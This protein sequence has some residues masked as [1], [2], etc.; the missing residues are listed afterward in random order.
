LPEPVETGAEPA[1]G[2]PSVARGSAPLFWAQIAGNAGLFAALVPI[3]R[4]LGPAGRGTLAFVT[5]TAIVAATVSRLGVTEATTV[6][7]AQRPRLRSVLLANVMLAVTVAAVAAAGVVCGAL[8]LAPGLRPPGVG[9]PELT[10]LA[11]GMVASA[12]AD[13]GYMFTLGCSRFRFHAAV[14]IAVAWLYAGTIAVVAL[15]A[16]LTVVSAAAIWVASQALKAAVLLVASARAEGVARPDG[17]L[18]AES[19]RFGLRAWI[20]S[21]SSAF[22]ERLDQILV[23]LLASEVA[24]GIYA[25]AVNAFEI[26]IYLASAAATAILPLVARAAPGARA[27]RVLAS[28]RSVALVTVAGIAV[29]AVVGPPLLPLMFGDPFEPSATP[30]LWLLPGAL[31]F[32]AMAIFSNALVASSAPGRS[33]IGPLVSLVLTLIG[34]VLLI[35][36]LGAEG[37]AIAASVA[38]VAGGGTALALYRLRDP[39]PMRALLV[40]RRGDLEL[41]RALARPFARR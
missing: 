39:F 19:V 24:L 34:D 8:L 4:Q 26:L 38:L 32:V 12:L 6:F 10:V 37:A 16:G 27:E 15:A 22:N 36:P 35:P 14:T 17:R 40:P 23:A 21:L 1:A 41:L 25:A 5:V 28:F 3:T 11:L 31:G 20:G 7:A 2:A 18:L 30:F 29:A 33:S 9:G 13:A